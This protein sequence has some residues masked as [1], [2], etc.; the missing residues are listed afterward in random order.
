MQRPG[1][2]G[3]G[4]LIELEA[5]LSLG[6]VAEVRPRVVLD[7]VITRTAQLTIAGHALG[8]DAGGQ[9]GIDRLVEHAVPGDW[10]AGRRI[11]VGYAEGVTT[12]DGEVVRQ[13][14]VP[15]RRVVAL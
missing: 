1:A 9:A 15:N 4:R 5:I 12:C 7:R 3:A 11:V 14:R 2:G 6:A 13:A 10:I 8:V